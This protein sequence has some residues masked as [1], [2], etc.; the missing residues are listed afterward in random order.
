[1]RPVSPSADDRPAMTKQ[2]HAAGPHPYPAPPHRRGCPRHRLA[3]Q[4][5]L[6]EDTSATAVVP[7]RPM[8]ADG[9]RGHRSCRGEQGGGPGRTERRSGSEPLAGSNGAWSMGPGGQ[10]ENGT[11]AWQFSDTASPL[12]VGRPCHAQ[13]STRRSCHEPCHASSECH[14]LVRI[15]AVPDSA[16]GG[17][18]THTGRILSPLPLPVGLRG[19]CD[20]ATCAGECR[21]SSGTLT[22]EAS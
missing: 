4:L 13:H 17:G 11:A 9:C 2:G 22:G 3:R 5:R 7:R 8:A 1:V 6:P 12:L 18:R 14:H 15:P 20:Q 16:P 21:Q 19:R 10:A